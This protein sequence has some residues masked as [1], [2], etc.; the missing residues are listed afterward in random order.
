MNDV[1]AAF[2]NDPRLIARPLRVVVC[3][4]GPTLIRA[5][6]FIIGSLGFGKMPGGSDNSYLAMN[7]ADELAGFA[8]RDDAIS[9]VVKHHLETGDISDHPL[10]RLARRST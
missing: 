3:Y 4:D 6:S 1:L 2:E 5:G 8:S 10:N 7:A 9:F